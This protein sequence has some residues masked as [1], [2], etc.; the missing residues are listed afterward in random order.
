MLF[1]LAKRKFDSDRAEGIANRKT[2]EDEMI[3]ALIL[4]HLNNSMRLATN[5]SNREMDEVRE[6]KTNNAKKVVEII[7]L[8]GSLAK[9]IGRVLNTNPAP[10]CGC[11]PKVKIIGKIIIADIRETKTVILLT[12]KLVFAIFSD[13]DM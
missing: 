5:T 11:I 4:C 6:V 3:T 12:I 2:A 7:K 10:A 9:R 1:Q 8:P 13:D